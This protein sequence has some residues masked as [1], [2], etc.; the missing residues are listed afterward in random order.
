M[1]LQKPGS[2]EKSRVNEEVAQELHKLVIK[3]F[4]KIKSFDCRFS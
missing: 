3:K 2:G 4:K 1:F